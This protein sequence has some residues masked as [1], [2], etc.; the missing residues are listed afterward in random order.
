M[1]RSDLEAEDPK[2][3]LPLDIRQLLEAQEDR[4]ALEQE[5]E[6]C[7]ELDWDEPE[8]QDEDKREQAEGL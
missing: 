8:D 1:A 2:E 3:R 5:R 4:Q 6:E 7:F